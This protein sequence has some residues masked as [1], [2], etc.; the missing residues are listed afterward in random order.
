MQCELVG[1]DLR[2]AYREA[3][4]VI[5]VQTKGL[6]AQLIM[7]AQKGSAH[8]FTVDTNMTERYPLV[9]KHYQAQL[10]WE[11]KLSYFFLCYSV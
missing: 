6:V 4:S 11:K 1:K 8:L 2:N 3:V 9:T 10:I 5:E 7:I